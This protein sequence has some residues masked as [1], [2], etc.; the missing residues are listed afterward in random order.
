MLVSYFDCS[1]LHFLVSSLMKSS[2]SQLY[3]VLFCAWLCLLKINITR[4]F[5]KW[6]FNC[7]FIILLCFYV[8]NGTL[9]FHLIMGQLISLCFFHTV[10]FCVFRPN[11]CLGAPKKYVDW[12]S[13]FGDFVHRGNVSLG[14]TSPSRCIW[15]LFRCCCP[16]SLAVYGFQGIWNPSLVHVCRD[17]CRVVRWIDPCSKVDFTLY[18]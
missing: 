6:I 15:R 3:L 4:C 13:D 16:P 12:T 17:R 11:A 7:L 8:Y 2:N 5:G 1:A 9:S 10:V 18:N 14:F